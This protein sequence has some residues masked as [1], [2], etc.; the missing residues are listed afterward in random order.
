MTAAP[1]RARSRLAVAVVMAALGLLVVAQLRGQ[2]SDQRLAG[3]SAQD[4]TILVANL[5]S[6]NDQLRTEVASLEG[7]LGAVA[8]A[9]ARGESATDQLRIDLTRIR[10]FSGLVAVHGPGVSITVAGPI[11]G[12]A[13]EA[14]LNELRNAGA[15]AIAVGA[16]RIV[17]GT[18]VAGL[19]GAVSVENS[20]LDD[21]FEIRAIGSPQILTGTLTR[22]GGVIAQL[23]ATYPGVT[24]TVTPLDAVLVPATD[25]D[26][27]PSHAH[28]R[29]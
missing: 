3:L 19:A 20:A 12:D 11:D 25:R 27:A 2:S 5:N 18:V 9:H 28:P 14:L 8:A 4:L 29:L 16:I 26:L 15:E 6:Q 10:T 17:P 13:V 22:A 21:P 1:R 23:A 24:V 7:E